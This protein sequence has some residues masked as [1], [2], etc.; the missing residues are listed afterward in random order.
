M[1]CQACGRPLTT[2]DEYRVACKNGHVWT[3]PEYADEPL[4]VGPGMPA[5]KPLVRL[6]K[7]PRWPAWL[8]GAV[9]G[10][11]GL[12]VAIVELVT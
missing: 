2:Y 11:A 9:L 6:V 4:T 12:I 8:P 7:A 10:S 3:L 5:G 1:N